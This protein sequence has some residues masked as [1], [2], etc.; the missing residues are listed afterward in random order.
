MTDGYR[1]ITN[2]NDWTLDCPEGPAGSKGVGQI[3]KQ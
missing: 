2:W 3:L 1:K